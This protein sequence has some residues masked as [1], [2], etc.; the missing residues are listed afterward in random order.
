MFDSAESGWYFII[1]LL[2]TVPVKLSCCGT[3]VMWHLNQR[4]SR[5][6]CGSLKP[7]FWEEIV[8]EIDGVLLEV[9][10]I[11]WGILTA[12]TNFVFEKSL[13]RQVR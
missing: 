3:E 10:I 12:E 2:S 13:I 8:A 5:V 9:I 11:G 7:C 6:G 4:G 1:I